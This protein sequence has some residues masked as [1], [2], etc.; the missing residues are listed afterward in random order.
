MQDKLLGRA[1]EIALPAFPIRAQLEIRRNELPATLGQNVSVLPESSS[2]LPYRNRGDGLQCWGTP[3]SDVNLRN[4]PRRP[5]VD[6]LFEPVPHPK[7]TGALARVLCR[8]GD[9]PFYYNESLLL[10]NVAAAYAKGKLND[11]TEDN[12]SV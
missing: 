12:G 7:M 3:S 8:K 11:P 10:V 1:L 9:R 5:C 6:P 4:W 2:H